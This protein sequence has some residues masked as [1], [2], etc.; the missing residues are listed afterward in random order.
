M[1]VDD[2]RLIVSAR[3]VEDDA[4]GIVGED[5]GQRGPRRGHLVECLDL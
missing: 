5:T 1:V 2:A 3:D 4:L